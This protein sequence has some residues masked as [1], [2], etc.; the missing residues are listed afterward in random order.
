V[1]RVTQHD[2][3]DDEEG[4]YVEHTYFNKATNTVKF[5]VHTDLLIRVSVFAITAKLTYTPIYMK[6]DDDNKGAF[7]E[8]PEEEYDLKNGEGRELPFPLQKEEGEEED[9]W[10]IRFGENVENVFRLRFSPKIEKEPAA[11]PE[12]STKALE[13]WMQ[14]MQLDPANVGALMKAVLD[15]GFTSMNE[16]DGATS[17]EIDEMMSDCKP[18]LKNRFKTKWAERQQEVYKRQ[19]TNP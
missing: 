19:K 12:P 15:Y 11:V 4:E 1:V 16:I 6:V 13:E 9:G 17:A 5:E 3:K 18:L 14:N 7:I 8:E 2:G 10:N